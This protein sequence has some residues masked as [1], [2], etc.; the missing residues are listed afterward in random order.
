LFS[1][2]A[3][4]EVARLLQ[5]CGSKRPDKKSKVQPTNTFIVPNN[6]EKKLHLNSGLSGFFAKKKAATQRSAR[7]ETNDATG[8]GQ[9]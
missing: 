3:L 4:L 9:T 2:Q 7:I 5:V 6:L 8:R 1:L